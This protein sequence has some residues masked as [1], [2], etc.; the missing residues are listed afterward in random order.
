M[1]FCKKKGKLDPNYECPFV[2]QKVYSKGAYVLT[3][4]EGDEIIPLTNAHF[5]RYY[6]ETDIH[7]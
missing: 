5:L 2:S 1:I 6:L 7:L 3:I 4:M